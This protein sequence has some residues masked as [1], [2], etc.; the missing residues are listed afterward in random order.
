M[1]HIDA[2][3]AS[4]AE[5]DNETRNSPIEPTIAHSFVQDLFPRL[6][7]ML[8]RKSAMNESVHIPQRQ[9]V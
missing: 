5:D 4:T 8:T 7:S 3:L 9:I 1:W 6:K 2:P